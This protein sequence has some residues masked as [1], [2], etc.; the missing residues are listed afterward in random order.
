[1]RITK[2]SFP[3]SEISHAKLE[4]EY[5]KALAILQWSK[6]WS[7]ISPFLC[8]QR[9]STTTIFRFLNLSTVRILP[10]MADQEKNATLKGAL[11]RQIH[12]QGKG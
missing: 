6:R 8:M 2:L 1:L 5:Y 12:L 3:T 10:N 11:H 7:T 9:Q 4:T